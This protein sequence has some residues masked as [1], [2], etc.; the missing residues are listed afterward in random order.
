MTLKVFLLVFG[1]ARPSAGSFRWGI[2]ILVCRKCL[3]GGVLQPVIVLFGREDPQAHI[4]HHPKLDL[5]KLFMGHVAEGPPGQYRPPFAWPQRG[6]ITVVCQ[7]F[8][9]KFLKL[10]S[11]YAQRAN[12]VKCRTQIAP[13]RPPICTTR[14]PANS[15][16]EAR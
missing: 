6:G 13:S 2:H 14:F 7:I 1:V 16:V 9:L 10:Y 15:A 12:P 4:L 3:H 5:C 8:F 11:C